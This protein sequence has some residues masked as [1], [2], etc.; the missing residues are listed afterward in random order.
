LVSRRQGA[1]LGATFV[2]VAVLLC[3]ATAWVHTA[4]T[5]HVTC[6]EH[7]ERVH[8]ALGGQHARDA[9][10]AGPAL[11]GAPIQSAAHAHEHCNLQSQGSGSAPVPTPTVV[12]ALFARA[13]VARAP[14]VRPAAALLR[15]APKTSPPR[16]PA[17]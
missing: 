9:R 16:A 12:P 5:P 2:V 13:P 11:T 14:R 17:V 7:G 6:L 8:L 10:D 3:Q 1:R 15:F 4:A